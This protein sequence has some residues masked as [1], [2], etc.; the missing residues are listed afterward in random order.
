MAFVDLP[1]KSGPSGLS[2]SGLGLS[3]TGPLTLELGT[4]SVSKHRDGLAHVLAAA[5]S[6]TFTPDPTNA[7][8]VFMALVNN[9]GSVDLWVDAYVDDGETV[10]GDPPSGYEVVLELTWFTIAAGETDLA[11][12]T[13][14][15]RTWV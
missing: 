12:A 6:H 13:I 10:R 8:R 5:Q 9:G 14:N 15:R 11:N 1:L 7:T 4:G 3:K 2:V